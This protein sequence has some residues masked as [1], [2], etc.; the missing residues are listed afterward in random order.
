MALCWLP[1]DSTGRAPGER[2]VRM[3]EEAAVLAIELAGALVPGVTHTVEV[4]AAT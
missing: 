3:P 2:R 1:S 4:T